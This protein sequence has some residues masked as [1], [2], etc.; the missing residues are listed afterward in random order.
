MTYEMQYLA[1]ILDELRA[2]RAI[3]SADGPPEASAYVADIELR[4]PKARRKQAAHK[5]EG[6]AG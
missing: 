6:E 1:A 2:I 5:P 4:E 3:L